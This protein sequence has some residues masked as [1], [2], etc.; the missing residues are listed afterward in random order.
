MIGITLKSR[1]K[2]NIL[3]KKKIMFKMKIKVIIIVIATRINLNQKIKS[4]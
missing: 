3:N 2:I 4:L 1:D